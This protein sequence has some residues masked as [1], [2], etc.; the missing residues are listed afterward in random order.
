MGIA[1]SRGMEQEA[2]LEFLS[3]SHTFQSSSVL[4]WRSRVLRGSCH[5]PR[6]VLYSTRGSPLQL[7]FFVVS[8]LWLRTPQEGAKEVVGLGH[9]TSPEVL[10]SL[11]FLHNKW[12]AD[13]G[14]KP[15]LVMVLKSSILLWWYRSNAE[16]SESSL[17][18]QKVTCTW[19]TI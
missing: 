16:A 17:N 8:P 14:N 11:S 6:P 13:F 7:L 2:L 19:S 10:K 18:F 5:M 1:D 15:K 4:P 3:L 12:G 9:K